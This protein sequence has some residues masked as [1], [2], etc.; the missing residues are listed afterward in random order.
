MTSRSRPCP[1][2]GATLRTPP[3]STLE[4]LPRRG[5]GRLLRV[6]ARQRLERGGGVGR[7]G[8]G[9]G[10]PRRDGSAG[11]R[12]PS[13]AYVHDLIEQ[14]YVGEVLSTTLI[15]S[16]RAIC[17][18]PPPAAGP[19]SSTSSYARRQGRAVVARDSA[20]AR[21]VS[22][23]AG[24][25][26]G[27]STNVAQAYARFAQD[28]REGTHLCPTFEDAVTRHRVLNAIETAAASGERQPLAAIRKSW[29]GC[30]A[31]P[32]SGA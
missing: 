2:A 19:R 31:Q 20:R 26:P 23:V 28:Y 22:V 3:A 5:Q 16:G 32:D 18:S 25:S 4:C 15:G 12:S 6:A 21:A 30:Q 14:G 13:V 17:S 27:P 24:A 9:K 7:S 11:A 29:P 8:K 1:R 10:G